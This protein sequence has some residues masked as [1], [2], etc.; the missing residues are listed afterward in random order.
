MK[1]MTRNF[2]VHEEVLT[3][4]VDQLMRPQKHGHIYKPFVSVSDTY[5]IE[6]HSDMFLTC[7]QHVKLCVRIFNYF[8]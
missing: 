5:R 4:I 7:V 2:E 6:T 1:F 8:F 3:S